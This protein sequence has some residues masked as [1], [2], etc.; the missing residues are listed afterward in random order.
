MKYYF[1]TFIISLITY[2]SI[3]APAHAAFIWSDWR[4]FFSL[5]T[6]G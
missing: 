6:G 4:V 2:L 5:V 1:S 3:Q